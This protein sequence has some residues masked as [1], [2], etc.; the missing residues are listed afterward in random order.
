[1]RGWWRHLST[2]AAIGITTPIAAA[3][4][5][6]PGINEPA[7]MRVEPFP[8]KK[9]ELTAPERMMR[10]ALKNINDNNI[11]ALL[12]AV[13]QILAQFPDYAD[14]YILRAT[15]LCLTNDTKA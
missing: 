4:I 9:I 14:A 7:E 2:I 13:D 3:P 15:A 11:N 1:M 12:P 6:I 5:L 8:A 10:E